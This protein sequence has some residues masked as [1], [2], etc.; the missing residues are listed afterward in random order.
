MNAVN[1][2]AEHEVIFS[3][4]VCS[5][6]KKIGIATLNRARSLNA[7]NLNIC[8]LLLQQL[9]RW[10]SNTDIVAVMLKGEG[11][12]GFCAGGDVAEVVRHVR[13]GR[14]NCFEYGDS[15][16]TVEYA[17][18]HLIH[19]YAKPLITWAH[20][21][22]MGGGVGLT[23]GGSHRIICDRVKVA[24]PEI[25]I[26]LFPDVG[27]GW[28]LNRTPGGTGLLMALTGIMINE[29]DTLFAGLADY[30]IPHSEQARFI[31]S[32]TQVQWGATTQDHR[33]QLTLHCR[34]FR[35]PFMTH[36]NVQP[37]ASLLYQQFANIAEAVGRAKVNGVVKGLDTLAKQDGRFKVA[38]A[39]LRNGSPT[40]AAVVFE[41]MQRTRQMSLREVLDLDLVLAKSFSRGHDFPEGVRALLIDKTK[42]AKWAPA[43]LSDVDAGLV[44][45]HFAPS[46]L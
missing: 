36:D 43:L 38:A 35:A 30:Y 23:V 27:G 18:D 42:D 2:N 1:V 33:N 39:N 22:T 9:R 40:A 7:L 21:I 15:F 31:E 29:A 14:A 10:Q 28:F 12:K 19:T 26:G 37:A 17:L 5:A 13:G 8:E 32:L 41:Y 24:M 44:E 16:F 25:H 11:D 20:G 46:N 34:E 45:R 6:D 4:I 3:E